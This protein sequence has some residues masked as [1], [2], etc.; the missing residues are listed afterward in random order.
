MRSASVARIEESSSVTLQVQLES[1]LEHG[2]S[3]WAEN[4]GMHSIVLFEGLRELI[5]GITSKQTRERL[6]RSARLNG[7]TLD[8]WPRTQFELAAQSHRRAVFRVLATVLENWPANFAHLIHECKL[9]YAD[10]KGDSDQRMF[11]F[12][13]V[14]RREAGSG[15]AAIGSDEAYS[16]CDAVIAKHGRF[17]Q[18]KAK[19]LSGRDIS[20]HLPDR[21]V[22]PVSDDVYEDL[23]TFIDH[24]VAGTLDKTRRACLIRDKIMFACGR[25]LGL[26]EG[27]LAKLTIDQI[28]SIVPEKAQL[29]FVDVARTPGQVRGWVEW[30]F[31]TMRP[32]L[33]PNPDVDYVF[34]SVG[35]RSGFSHSAVC[36]RFSKAVDAAMLRRAIPNYR[37]WVYGVTPP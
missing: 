9:R 23:L 26:S 6:K 3:D 5:A 18:G 1:A 11:W 32:L 13:D 31:D 36:A 4:P 34:T 35:T 25:M 37:C 24:Q 10:L 28:R 30:Y 15:Y 20:L 21:K 29:S 16:I 8:D 22:S 17:S 27:G 14:I 12:E 33:Y 2:F 19:S 7:R